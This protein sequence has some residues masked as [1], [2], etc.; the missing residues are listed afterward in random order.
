MFGLAED[1]Y[2]ALCTEGEDQCVIISG[3][4]GAGKTEAS[5][6]IMQYVAA[7]TGSGPDIERVKNQLLRS[8]PV[9]EAF[10]NAKTQRNNNS[11]RFGKYL[12]IHFDYKG[13]P[14]G[15]VVQNF[16]LEKSRV[17]GQLPDERSFHIFY[18]ILAGVNAAERARLQ[19]LP[20]AASYSYL[21][22]NGTYSVDRMDDKEEYR[23]CVE[24]MAA[25]GMSEAEIGQ[26]RAV[27]AAVLW[28]GQVEFVAEGADKC[29]VADPRPIEIVAQLLACDQRLLAQGMVSR[30]YSANNSSVLTPLNADQAKYTRD[31]LAK[32]TYF[33]L[34]DYIVSVINSAI[35]TNDAVAAS[36]SKSKSKTVRT[37][38]VLDIYG[39]PIDPPTGARHSRL[40]GA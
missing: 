32:A 34:F 26:V 3:E 18:Q 15:G 24:G 6:K 14:V 23:D 8:N 20:S 5:K 36:A 10:G 19:L 1:T 30:T 25:M 17:V 28:L 11:S 16:L 40:S 7:V 22:A 37:I 33:R 21:N 39:Q 31:A 2:R 35:K 12:S 38:G 13:D 4:S 27:L 29:R 9:L